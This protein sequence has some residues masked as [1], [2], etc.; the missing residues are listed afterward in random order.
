MKLSHLFVLLLAVSLAYSQEISKIHMKNG[1]MV[2]GQIIETVPD[3]YI[4]VEMK[5]GSIM[6]FQLA[7]VA[8]IEPIP[9]AKQGS[10]GLG[11]GIPYGTLGANVDYAIND[12]ISLTGGIG[13]SVFAGPAYNVGIKLYLKGVGQ[14]AR[15]RV[16]AY[17][18]VNA[19]I[20]VLDEMT[21]EFLVQET[22]HGLSV[23]IGQQWMWGD[24]RNKGLDVD[25]ML[26]VTSTYKDRAP[27]VEDEYGTELTEFG[28]IKISIGYRFGF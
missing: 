22:H 26:I 7:D 8:R 15:P 21:D 28:D 4:R 2:K 24:R 20:V 27:E 19:V 1:D 14:K 9:V 3:Q 25:L 17:Y 13:T 5:D 16:S 18:G 23:G 10:M 6:T 11:L 12:Y